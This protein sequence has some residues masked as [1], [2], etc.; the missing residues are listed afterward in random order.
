MNAKIYAAVA[1]CASAGFCFAPDSA[2]TVS[3]AGVTL[4]SVEVTF[5]QSDRLF[6][7]QNA[8]AINSN[9]LTCHSASMVLNQPQLSRATWGEEVAKMR[10][11]YGAPVPDESV[12]AIVD[13]LAELSPKD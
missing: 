8:D 4:N 5:P 11:V 12:P 10:K 6:P 1:L 13:Y 2:K 9:C 3:A 7:G